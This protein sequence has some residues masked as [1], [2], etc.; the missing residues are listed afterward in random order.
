MD[1]PESLVAQDARRGGPL[2][3][4]R[5]E[6]SRRPGERPGKL[7]IRLWQIGEWRSDDLPANS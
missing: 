6:G 2:K 1:G 4:A 7:G 3:I 5:S